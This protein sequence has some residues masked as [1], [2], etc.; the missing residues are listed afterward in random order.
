MVLGICIALAIHL[1]SR[2]VTLLHD[3][4]QLMLVVDAVVW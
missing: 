3:L 1:C 4:V 2:A